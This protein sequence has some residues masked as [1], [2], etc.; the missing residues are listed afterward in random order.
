MA[1][2]SACPKRSGVSLAVQSVA[3]E[4][5]HY[6]DLCWHTLVCSCRQNIHSG[7]DIKVPQSSCWQFSVNFVQEIDG[8]GE[9]LVLVRQKCHDVLSVV[10]LAHLVFCFRCAFERG[11]VYLAHLYVVGILGPFDKNK[12]LEELLSHKCRVGQY[13]S[14]LL[15]F[16]HRRQSKLKAVN[17]F[18]VNVVG[19]SCPYVSVKVMRSACALWISFPINAF[20]GTMLAISTGKTTFSSWSLLLVFVVAVSW[21]AFTGFPFISSCL[22]YPF[23]FA[24][25]ISSVGDNS[26]C[27]LFCSMH[28][29]R[30]NKWLFREKRRK[31]KTDTKKKKWSASIS[32]LLPNCE[33]ETSLNLRHLSFLHLIQAYLGIRK[34]YTHGRRDVWKG[35]VVG[36]W[37]SREIALEHMD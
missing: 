1:L 34:L 4:S 5:T 35:F 30:G 11:R 7:R 10:L 27:I 33:N 25:S 3:H 21:T 31:S 15:H 19:A 18:T 6:F 24:D 36:S 37:R 23:V 26:G 32:S 14:F 9:Y 17:N 29:K 8:G 13:L 22:A 16:A 28:K 2:A 20:K 12:Q